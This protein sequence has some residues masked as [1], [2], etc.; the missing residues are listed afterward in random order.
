MVN[1]RQQI[2]M[3]KAI[4]TKDIDTTD[5]PELTEEAWSAAERSKFYRPKK[6]QKTV[7]IDADILNWLESKGPGYQTRINTILREAMIRKA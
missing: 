2:D 6:V 1:K 5:A 7:R 3:L 4:E